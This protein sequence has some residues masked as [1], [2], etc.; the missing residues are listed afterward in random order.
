MLVISHEQGRTP[1][2]LFWR[3]LERYL[4]ANGDRWAGRRQ[5]LAVAARLAEPA[6]SL[7][8][9]LGI[10][11]FRFPGTI[12]LLDLPPKRPDIVHGHNLHGDYFDL[13]ALTWLSRKTPVVLTLHDSWL[14]TGHCAQSFDCMRWKTGCGQCP[15]LTIYPDLRRD[16]TAYNWQRKKAIYARSRLFVATPSAWLMN[17]VEHSILAP[18]IAD[19]RIIPNGVDLSVFKPGDK[20]AVRNELAI[21][22]HARVLLCVAS[23][24]RHNQF[25]DYQTVAKAAG[26]IAGQSDTFQTLLFALGE[27]A[28]AERIGRCQVRFVPFESDPA[29]VAKYYQAAD[30]Y[31]HAARADSFPTTVLEALVCGTPVIATAIGGIPEQIRSLDLP[32]ATK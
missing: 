15:D 18:A 8:R 16:R 27:S 9:L 28:E 12:G 24:I 21:P 2:Y 31:L 14:L 1:W 17:R 20:K 10:E 25:R 22:Q 11:C 4:S 5:L 3:K 13:R 32:S 26:I 30:I 23:G 6:Q 19:A 29:A 7:D